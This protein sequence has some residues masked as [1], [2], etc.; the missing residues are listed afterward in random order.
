MHLEVWVSQDVVASTVVRSTGRFT[1]V[2]ANRTV[3]LDDQHTR[4]DLDRPSSNQDGEI[5]TMW[6][7]FVE[8]ESS[9]DWSDAMACYENLLDK[10]I[11]R[12]DE[13]VRTATTTKIQK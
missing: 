9:G 5:S 6:E 4:R 13:E 11:A 10:V 12:K 1:S 3:F 7:R 8:Y 2:F